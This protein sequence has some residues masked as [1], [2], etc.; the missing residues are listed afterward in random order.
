MASLSTSSDGSRRLIFTDPLDGKRKTIYLGKMTE[1]ATGKFKR[2]LE[3][4]LVYRGEN[5]PHDASLI[6]WLA[7]LSDELAGKLAALGLIE[8][9]SKPDAEA[10]PS[11]AAFIP[12]FLDGKPHLKETA[13]TA[14]KVSLNQA[15]FYLG[16]ARRLNEVDE[17]AAAGMVRDMTTADYAKATISKA[18]IAMRSMFKAAMRQGLTNRNPFEF[19]KP[20]SQSNDKRKVFIPADTVRKLIETLPG[21]E[22]PLLVALARWGGLRVPSEPFALKWSDVLWDQNRLIVPCPKMEHLPGRE[23]RIIPIFP[24]VKP[25][26]DARWENAQEGEVYVFATIRKLAGIST[27]LS[28][29][30][31]AAGIE[32]WPRTWQNLRASR[33]TELADKFPSH[34]AAAWLGHS[35]TIADK[36]YRSVLDSHFDE[37]TR[38]PTR[39]RPEK[40]GNQ[41]TGVPDENVKTPGKQAFSDV[42]QKSGMTLTGFEPVSRP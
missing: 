34:V 10:V 37:A 15:A 36:H 12:V 3:T 11:L 17:R 14:C 8:P 22:W 32:S 35:E 20:G 13:R 28:K 2:N 1:N 4:L 38:F 6:R 41:W 31:D 16:N 39:F 29:R 18:V 33:A 26:L 42:S 30:I 7:S 21:T 9:R 24:E 5:E 25:F 19:L 27:L 23:K 40:G